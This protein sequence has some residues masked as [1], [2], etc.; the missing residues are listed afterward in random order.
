[1]N[2]AA[3]ELFQIDETMLVQTLRDLKVKNEEEVSAI[4]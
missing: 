3:E 1:M 2:H 4:A